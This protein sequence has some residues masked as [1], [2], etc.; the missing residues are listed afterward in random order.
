MSM[1]VPKHRPVLVT[2]PAASPVSL[3]D[4]KKALHVQ[5]SED[6]GR[7][8]DEIDAAVAHYE[9]PDGILGG[10]ILS[11]QRWRQDYDRVEQRLLLP[12]RPVGDVVSVTW[13]DEAGAESTIGNTNYARLTDAGGRYY[14]LFHDS[15]ELPNYLYEVAGASVE[16]AAGY[17][18]VPADIKTAI[19]VRVQSQ[20]DEA[21]SANGQN[22][23]R[24]EANLIRKY[25][26]P[27][28]A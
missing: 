22:L 21:A 20:Y 11:E 13:K 16:F 7:L 1:L 8:Q 19:I 26:R 24:I 9:G 2:P 3:A 6:D 28:I 17:E 25:R 5:H 27:G 18:T 23:E 4:V 15:Y 12:L 14:L 10:V